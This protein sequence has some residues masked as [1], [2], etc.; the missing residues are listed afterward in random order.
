ML[1]LFLLSIMFSSALTIKSVNANENQLLSV[2]V[3]S[4]QNNTYTVN[5]SVPLAI[6]VDNSACWIGYSLNDQAN[7]T[8]AGNTTL[9]TL[10]DGFY[11]L[12]VY[13]NDTSDRMAACSRRD[14]I[15]DTIPPT[16]SIMINDGATSIS[17]AS[18]TL[19]LS[20]YDAVSGVAQMR[21]FYVSW[22]DWE[23]YATSKPWEF[24]DGEDYKYVYVQFKDNAGLISSPYRVRVILGTADQSDLNVTS[25]PLE[26]LDGSSDVPAIK[27]T[28]QETVPSSSPMLLP[29]STP[30]NSGNE[31]LSTIIAPETSSIFQ[32]V[33]E[34][35]AVGTV[36]IVAIFVAIIV[37]VKKYQ[38]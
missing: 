34:Y 8:F 6:I 9:P 22:G 19:T 25:V 27:E 10:S 30:I 3:L 18:V 7:V 17:D 36:L 28:P 23:A 33:V 4:P 29:T 31:A 24:P 21:F 14:F 32:S 20:A 38:R 13:A 12:I 15:V 16:G 11:H 35:I 2:T 1:F 26:I 5:S 37:Y